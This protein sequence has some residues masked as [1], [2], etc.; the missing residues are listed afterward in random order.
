M[1]NENI[2][3]LIANAKETN[4]ESLNLSGQN[5]TEI[6]KEIF[7]LRNLKN[8]SLKENQIMEI[9]KEIK[10]L[11]ELT[12]LSIGQ[13]QLKDLPAEFFELKN[14]ENLSL[15]KNK[16]KVISNRFGSFKK[17]QTLSLIGN[18]IE[19]I[20]EG[21]CD[22]WLLKNLYLRSNNLK[23]LPEKFGNL[24][25]LRNLTLDNNPIEYPDPIIIKSGLMRIMLFFLVNEKSKNN[26]SGFSFR[27]PEEMKTAVKQYLIYFQEY[28]EKTKG[29]HIEFEIRSTEDGV[30]IETS[31]DD[32]LQEINTYFNEY[33]G[34]VKNN[35]D[36]IVPNFEIPLT[37]TKREVLALELKQQ[38]FH[39]KQQLELKNFQVKFLENQVSEYYNLLSLQNARPIPIYVNAITSSSAQSV[40]ESNA[41]LQNE[42]IVEMRL[43]FP[44]LQK[45][46][47]GLKIDDETPEDLKRELE[48]IDTELLNIDMEELESVD[49]KPFK[50]IKR[51]F[52]QMTNE[53]SSLNE[54]IK[55]SKHL[56]ENLQGLGKSY[57]KFAQ[58]LALPVIPNIFL[59]I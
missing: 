23:R 1:I 12:L 52:E 8:L 44:D 21:F 20:E 40:S 30:M 33:L 5:L 56:K 25:G 4:A 24:I 32:G 13:N 38:V 15:K 41:S 39:F 16:L 42:N 2:L 55:K 26:I 43:E 3:Q 7:E 45:K 36:D 11:A 35:I 27:V 50:R 51:L 54:A 58:W 18:E 48:V 37:E 19:I 49:K 53:E 59:E 17:L 6:P 10:N 57:N 9:P 47:L 29:K 46:L 22:M 34:F 14:L 31:K 28:V